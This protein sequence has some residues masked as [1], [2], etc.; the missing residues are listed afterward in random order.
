MAE[1]LANFGYLGLVKEVTKG[2]A[3]TPTDF[4]PLYKENM[5]TEW[6]LVDDNPIAGN[7]WARYQ[8]LPGMRAHKGDFEVMAEPNTTARFVDMLL[9][10]GTTTGAGPFTHPFTLSSATNPNSYTVDVSSG[11]QVFRFYGVEA[12][13]LTPTWDKTE[14]HLN[15]TVSALGSFMGRTIA[16]VTTTTLTLDTT[17]DPA[18]NKGLVTGDL[19]R[20]YKS[21]TGATLDTT[22]ATVAGDGIT[23]TLGASAA[24]FAAGDTIT[25]R[26][27]TPTY[28]NLVPFLWPK[29]QFCFGATA[30][31]A[32]SAVQTRL[33]SGSNWEIV[34]KFEADSGA[35]RSGAFDPAALVRTQGD[36]TFK[37]KKFF[38]TP[39][40]VQQFLSIAK[41]S[42]VIRHYSGATNQYELRVTLNDLRIKMGVDPKADTGKILYADIEYSPV[43]SQTDAQ[44]VDVKMLNNLS[45]I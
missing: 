1:R 43:Y 4:V 17:Y 25:L 38:D 12:S 3:L 8:V 22:I 19:V 7:K 32:L 33:E 11:N 24:A 18:P 9:T 44:A 41:N 6:N 28:T 34:H 42:C 21:A 37:I 5:S 40:D 13:K 39:E 30:S 31:A 2:T 35:E 36:A 10:K 45:A 29:T 20:I 15:V 23:V 27:A 26:P 16:T 14:M